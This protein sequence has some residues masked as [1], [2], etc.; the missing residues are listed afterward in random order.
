MPVIAYTDG[1]ANN[2]RPI[3][4][5]AGGWGV[6]MMLVDEQGQRDPRQE[7]YRELSGGVPSATNNQ[8]ELEAVRQA[9]LALKGQGVQI[10]IVS[11]SSYT[12]G[13][14][15]MNWKVKENISLVQEIKQMMRH[16]RVTFDKVKGH[17]GH[18]HNERADTLAVAA[19]KQGES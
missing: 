17:A 5:R 9:L 12:I 8:M 3:E 7:A 11:D 1:A 14:L 10:T 6:V 18:E 13:V 4:Q 2:A 15:S 16:H 19:R